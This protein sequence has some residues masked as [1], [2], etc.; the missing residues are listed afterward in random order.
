MSYDEKSTSHRKTMP[1]IQTTVNLKKLVAE[2]EKLDL[3]M[4]RD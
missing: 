4:F 1:T 2:L 3:I